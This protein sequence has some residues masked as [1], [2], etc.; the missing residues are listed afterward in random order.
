VTFKAVFL[1]SSALL[2]ILPSPVLLAGEWYVDSSVAESGSGQS[3]ETAFKAIQQGIN[4]ALDG[5]QVIVAPGTYMERIHFK[6]KSI[7]LMSTGPLDQHIVSTTIIDGTHKVGG[8]VVTFAGNE[9]ESCI[10]SGFT[11]QN[12]KADNGGGILGGDPY[13]DHTRATIKNNVITG[14]VADGVEYG[15]GGGGIAHC[16][17]IIQSNVIIGNSSTG[18]GGGLARCHGIIHSNE[19]INNSAGGLVGGGGVYDCDGTI[20]N[21]LISGNS[22]AEYGGGICQCGGLILNNTITRNSS[23]RPGGGFDG[24]SATI[25]NCIIWGNTPDQVFDSTN[26]FFS[27]IQDWPGGGNGNIS[28]TPLFANLKYGDYHL[29]ADSPCVDAGANGYW[30]G[31]SQHDEDGNCRLTGQ[32]VDMGCYEYGSSSDSDGDVLSATA[33]SKTGTDPLSQDTDGDGLRD[34][35]EV[36]RG[37]NPLVPTNPA[38]LSVP[39]DLHTIQLALCVAFRGEEIIVSSGTY[40]ES[41]RFFGTD[42]ILRSSN[43]ENGDTVA[44]TIIDGG[45]SGPA[46]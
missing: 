43:P 38:A 5:D 23:G 7:V 19:I 32:R 16:D 17:G 14:N 18:P 1:L 10:L 31:W 4:A 36:L 3:W 46:V 28:E 33:E 12:G 25:G 27:C 6:G 30:F 2:L 39:S 29:Q 35:L 15:D 11:I 41:I 44:S 20:Q 40:H 42:V 24:C 45:T 37:S 34:G 13:G 26:P 22:S 21:N 9:N 8:S